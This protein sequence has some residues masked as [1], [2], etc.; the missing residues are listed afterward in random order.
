M[1]RKHKKDTFGLKAFLHKVIDGMSCQELIKSG[2][3]RC[4]SADRIYDTMT[5]EQRKEALPILRR[6]IE[7]DER[8]AARIRRAVP[9]ERPG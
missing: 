8:A 1:A 9:R 2:I 3:I 7:A 6:M 5:P 4:V